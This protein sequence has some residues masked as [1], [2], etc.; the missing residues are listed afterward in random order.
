[1]WRMKR[2]FFLRWLPCAAGVLLASGVIHAASAVTQ[3]APD[4]MEQRLAACTSCHGAY[5]AG[6]PDDTR[7]PRLAGKPAGYLLQQLRHFRSGQRRHAPMEYVVRQLS[8]EYLRR[9]AAYYAR[10]EVP[11]HEHPVPQVSADVLRRGKQLVFHGD[12]DRGVP[13]CMSCHGDRLTGVQP[14][15]PGL[16]GLTY[17]Y[18]GTQ[19]ELWRS[20]GRADEGMFCM[21]VVANRMR[22]SDITAVSAWLASQT[23]P[24]DMRPLSSRADAEPLPGWCVLGEHEV[25]P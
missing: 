15:M 10:Q 14:M 18:I 23:P 11:I 5:G 21:G 24:D 17:D 8:P 20:H 9:I 2:T 6:S 22:K 12:P 13:S 4:T 3:T 19:L 25:T 1:M 16:V 7:I